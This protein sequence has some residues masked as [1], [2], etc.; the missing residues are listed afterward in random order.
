MIDVKALAERIYLNKVKNRFPTD[1][2]EHDLK[3]LRKEAQEAIDASDDV[4]LGREL[5]DVVIFAIG[6]ARMRNIDLTEQVYNKVSY[7]ETREYKK[8]TFRLPESDLDDKRAE[9]S[10]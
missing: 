3:L 5:A 9:I 10:D 6:I 2:L 8:E 4:E 7:N 1:D